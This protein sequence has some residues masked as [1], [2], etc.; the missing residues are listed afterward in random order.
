MSLC[1]LGSARR[2]E[3]TQAAVSALLMGEMI[4]DVEMDVRDE[5]EEMKEWEEAQ[6]R[7]AGGGGVSA[8]QSEGKTHSAQPDKAPSCPPRRCFALRDLVSAKRWAR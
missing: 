2:Y 3:R 6:I 7:R 1:E 4:D 8:C 5:D